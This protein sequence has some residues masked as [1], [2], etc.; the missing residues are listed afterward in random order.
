MNLCF[1]VFICLGTVPLITDK[2]YPYSKQEYDD[3]EDRLNRFTH[4]LESKRRAYQMSSR[5]RS[6]DRSRS[7]DRKSSKSINESK[8]R[9]HK[10][11]RR[12]RSP[13]SSHKK[14][15]HKREYKKKSNSKSNC[16]STKRSK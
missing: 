4:Y 14:S 13:S 11:S 15:H 1:N 6:K 10:R 7:R 5:D 12:S 9:S 8:H 2:I 16:T 3:Y